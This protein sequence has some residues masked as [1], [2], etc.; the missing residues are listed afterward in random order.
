MPH[1]KERTAA[2]PFSDAA[3]NIIESMTRV[4]M[5]RELTRKERLEF[6]AEITD[7]LRWQLDAPNVVRIRPAS[8]DAEA[9]R[10]KEKALAW[11]E[12]TAAK[13][14]AEITR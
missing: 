8:L 7:D 11:W 6:L 13:L 1:S 4:Y 10:E 14:A 9:L 2:L 5:R 12:V 3:L